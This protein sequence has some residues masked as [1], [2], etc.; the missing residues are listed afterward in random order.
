MRR[1]FRILATGACCRSMIQQIPQYYYSQRKRFMTDKKPEVAPKAETAPAKEDKKI[2]K[3]TAEERK[4]EKKEKKDR[5]QGAKQEKAAKKAQE[6]TYVKDPKD[7]CASKFGDFELVTSKCN[8]E[9]SAKIAYTQI[10][11]LADELVGRQVRVRARLHNSRIKGKMGFVVLRD[12]FYTAQCVLTVGAELSA[13]MMKYV[14]SIPKESLVEVVAK[15]TKPGAEIKGCSQKV[16]LTIVEFWTVSRCTPV[17]P[18]QF[19]DATRKVLN[20][21]DEEGEAK[22]A[23]S[24]EDKKD[25]EVRVLQVTRL[26]NRV[27]DLRIP[28]NQAIMRIQSGVGRF[29]REFLYNK[30]FVEIHSPKIIPG[31]SEGGTEVFKVNYFGKDACLAQSPQLYKQ[32]GVCGDITRV[33][34]IAPVF[35]AENSNTNRHLC[36]FTML[37][38]EMAFNNHY[39]EVMELLGNM[40]NY[41]FEHLAE[42]YKKELSV[43]NEQY[44][45]EPFKWKVPTVKINFQEGVKMLTEAGVKQDP[46][47]D[48]NSESEK[49]LGDLVRKKYDTDFYMLYGFPVSAR[50][51]YTM[52]DPHNDAYTNS[53]DFFMRGEEITSGSQRVHEPKLLSE[54]AA[55]AGI[56]LDTLKDYIDAFRYGAPPHAGCGIG[57]ERVVKLFC[58]LR[59]IRKCIMFTRDPK[60]LTP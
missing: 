13:G 16:E 6:E 58:G 40:F 46:K 25:K 47:A 34:E 42:S 55:A 27:F 54:R 29:F 31:V 33:F 41:I 20:Q 17:L 50:P 32:M 45:F 51:F 22:S 21:E 5:K 4:R 36:E 8:P 24:E 43:I 12:T 2:V 28:T 38:V 37:D 52:R 35:R 19:E 14:K 44:P 18:F 56:P 11:Q 15:V 48:L 7:P 30:E 23:T 9:E 3:K 26:D 10:S 59:N 49:A 1:I 60:R 57:L 53:Y 39:F